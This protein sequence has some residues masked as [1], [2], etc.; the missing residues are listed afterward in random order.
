MISPTCS[1]KHFVNSLSDKDI[2]EIIHLADQEALQA[3]RLTRKR[4][5]DEEPDK[6]LCESYQKKVIALIHYLRYESISCDITQ[7]ECKMF[8]SLKLR[9]DQEWST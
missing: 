1:I 8:E 6:A 3:W 5:S 4:N 2:P 7:Q 9:A